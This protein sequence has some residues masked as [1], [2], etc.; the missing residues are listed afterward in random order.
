MT[1][2]HNAIFT[3]P[4]WFCSSIFFLFHQWCICGE[5]KIENCTK[6]LWVVH[7]FR[8]SGSVLV[9]IEQVQHGH[10]V[11][12]GLFW[13]PDDIILTICSSQGFQY[14]YIN[15]LN[16]GLIWC[17]P[18]KDRNGSEHESLPPLSLSLKSTSHI[19]VNLHKKAP[20]QSTTP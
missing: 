2:P 3:L 4:F 13:H 5:S 9:L 20:P 11:L 8:W 17:F 12:W 7:F 15:Q 14:T 16:K 19:H 6:N 1:E 18:K 10:H